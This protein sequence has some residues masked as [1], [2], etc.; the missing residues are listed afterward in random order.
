ME[1]SAFSNIVKWAKL[2]ITLVIIGPNSIQTRGTDLT[3]KP[4]HAT[5]PLKRLLERVGPEQLS[6][7]LGLNITSLGFQGPPLMALEMDL[8]ASKSLLPAPYK[9]QVRTLTVKPIPAGGLGWRL[10][11]VLHVRNI[12]NKSPINAARETSSTLTVRQHSILECSKS[13]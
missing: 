4:S 10:W 9:Q 1:I 3:Q 5:I 6:T 13:F 2:C 11:R 8:P 7:F 12:S